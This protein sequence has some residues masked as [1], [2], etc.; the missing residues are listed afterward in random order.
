MDILSQ[1]NFFGL[2]IMHLLD[3]GKS[4]SVEEFEAISD[5]EDIVEYIG[6]TYGFKNLNSTPDNQR[7]LK[8]RLKEIYISEGEARKS[9]IENN[10]L[11]YLLSI[12]FDMA[13]RDA[14]DYKWNYEDLLEERK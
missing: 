12:L 6:R 13:I 14:Y 11:V 10:G 9:N 8:E 7:L 4:M 3:Q 2:E 1:I 5:N